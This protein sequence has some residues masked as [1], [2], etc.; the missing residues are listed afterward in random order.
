MTHSVY[1]LLAVDSAARSAA[2]YADLL[3]LAPVE[4]SPTFALFALPQGPMLGLWGRAGM[5]PSPGPAGGCEV[6]FPVES[7]AALRERLADWTARGAPVLQPLT[8]MDFGET[9]V[10]A[11]PDGHRLRAFCP[12]GA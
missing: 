7:G 10:V 3:G 6:A 11:D 1:I 8:A 2:F 12:A 5:V 9:F 4:S